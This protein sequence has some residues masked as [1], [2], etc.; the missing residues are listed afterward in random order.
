MNTV[1]I[2]NFDV[3]W[4]GTGGAGLVK[5]DGSNWTL[6]S[7]FNSSIPDNYVNA[8]AIDAYSNK[9]IGTSNGLAKFDGVNWTIYRTANS[10]LPSNSIRTVAIGYAGNVWIGTAF[11]GVAKFGGSNWTIFNSS[12]SSLPSNQISF[13]LVDRRNNKWIGTA[14]GLA[15]YRENG[16]LIKVEE[17]KEFKNFSYKLYQNYPNPANPN[18]VI[19]FELSKETNVSLEL[20]NSLGQKIIT[21]YEGN[22]LAGTHEVELNGDN[23]STGVYFYVLK[24]GEFI[25]TKKMMILK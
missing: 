19:R 16:V 21:L 23:L 15:V 20:Y 5:F 14:N 24:A 6:Y 1:T 11:G 2:D 12:N 8:I 17:N 9:W 13:I 4:I 3:K 10:G 25:E 18:T 7:T 22:L